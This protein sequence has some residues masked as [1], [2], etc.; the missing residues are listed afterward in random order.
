MMNILSYEV[1]T[2]RGQGQLL[3]YIGVGVAVIALV[4]LFHPGGI[5]QRVVAIDSS[6]GR[7]NIWRVG[8]AAYPDYCALGSGWGTFPDV[9]EAT[10]QPTSPGA[11]ASAPTAPT[12]RTTYC[13]WSALS[14]GLR[15]CSS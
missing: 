1:S 15:D 6:S 10:T 13:S 14:S 7:S 9:Y 12:S 2:R 11:E 4:F 3:A 8:L 5:A